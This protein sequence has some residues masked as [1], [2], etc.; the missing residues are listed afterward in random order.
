MGY[1]SRIPEDVMIV[2][3]CRELTDTK[4][5]NFQETDHYTMTY[6]YTS[7]LHLVVSVFKIISQW[8]VNSMYA[9]DINLFNSQNCLVVCPQNDESVVLSA[10]TLSSELLL[11]TMC[12]MVRED[13]NQM[14]GSRRKDVDPKS[15]VHLQG[16]VRRCFTNRN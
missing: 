6:H 3:Q 16:T 7:K 8:Q 4:K 10:Y 14:S 2:I 12:P 13:Q 15:C 5:T 1:I 11:I 9:A